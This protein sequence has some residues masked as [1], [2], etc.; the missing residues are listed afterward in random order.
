[1]SIH[2]LEMHN[3]VGRSAW[4]NQMR[5]SIKRVASYR[6][7]VLIVGPS[8]TGKELIASAIHRQSPRCSAPFVAVDC[9]SI[10]P[11]L[12]ASQLFGHVKGA[13]SGAEYNTLG[14]FRAAEGGTIFLDEIGELSCRSNISST[15]QRMS[16][17]LY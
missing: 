5:R 14:N 8:G 2:G 1:M 4:S 10:P 15:F 12:F 7:S 3:I 16:Y 13:F 6:S 17:H 9:A 11:A